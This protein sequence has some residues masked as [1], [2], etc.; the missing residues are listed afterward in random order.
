MEVGM[1][2][3]FVLEKQRGVHF[4]VGWREGTCFYGLTY[5]DLLRVYFFSRSLAKQHDFQLFAIKNAV[6]FQ[7]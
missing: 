4:N 3:V 6:S 2:S 5:L 7:K 1:G